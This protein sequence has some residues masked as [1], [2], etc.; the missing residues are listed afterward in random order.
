MPDYPVRDGAGN[1][2]VAGYEVDQTALDP[3]PISGH[4]PTRDGNDAIIIP[5]RGIVPASPPVKADTSG[6]SIVSSYPVKDGLGNDIITFGTG[7]G[8]VPVSPLMTETVRFAGRADVN[9]GTTY[10]QV[11]AMQSHF[12]YARIIVLNDLA[13]TYEIE[14]AALAPSAKRNDDAMP[15]TAADTAVPFTR[16]TFGNGGAFT[17]L[18]DQP[19]SPTVQTLVV[20]AATNANNPTMVASDW[21]AISSLDRVDSADGFPLLFSRYKTS[22][23][24]NGRGGSGIAADDYT[25]AAKWPAV[26]QGRVI[27]IQR[28]GSNWFTNGNV[29][30]SGTLTEQSLRP[31]VGIQIMSRVAGITVMGLGDSLMQALGSVI[32]ANSFLHQTA[33]AVSTPTKPVAHVPAGWQGQ[34]YVDTFARGKYL[35]DLFRPSILFTFAMSLNGGSNDAAKFATMRTQFLDLITYAKARGVRIVAVT[36][37]P[38]NQ[39]APIETLRT[40]YN[41][42]LRSR[43]AN[44]EFRLHDLDRC[45]RDPANPNVSQTAYRVNPGVDE[46]LNDAGHAAGANG[47]VA[48]PGN[49]VDGAIKVLQ[50][51]I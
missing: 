2:I 9:S 50:S 49:S 4:Y 14:G 38:Y 23:A 42:E 46:H 15:L 21:A 26:S 43:A 34:A 44:G 11:M 1:I 8:R 25:D 36:Y 12:D 16:L 33:C 29:W 3:N 19:A 41:D 10:C 24:A 17:A 6:R 5:D 27:R 20:P 51:L 45:V 47:I 40:E 28:R 32:N 18:A 7:G 30:A 31:F 13:T 48:E 35:I 37:P 22:A 39:T